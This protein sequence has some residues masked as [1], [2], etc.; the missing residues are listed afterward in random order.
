MSVYSLQSLLKQHWEPGEPQPPL[1]DLST[2]FP[3][4]FTPL[5]LVMSSAATHLTWAGGENSP[6]IAQFELCQLFP[7]G[8]VSDTGYGI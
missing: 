8:T 7:V 1:V 5:Q 4:P 3:P 2:W 6:Q